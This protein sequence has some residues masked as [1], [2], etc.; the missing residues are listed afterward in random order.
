MATPQH[1]KKYWSYNK[2]FYVSGVSGRWRIYAADGSIADNDVFE[3]L[4]RAQIAMNQ[5]G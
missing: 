1:L 5:L 4:H 2:K 3:K